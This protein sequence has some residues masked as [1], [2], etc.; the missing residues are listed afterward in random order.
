MDRGEAIFLEDFAHEKCGVVCAVGSGHPG[1]DVSEHAAGEFEDLGFRSL[2][3]SRDLELRFCHSCAEG[4]ECKG[5][6]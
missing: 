6:E 1:A 2:L 4:Q 5:E 3:E